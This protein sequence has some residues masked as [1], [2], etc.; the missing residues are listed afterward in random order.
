M[1]SSPNPGPEV[2]RGLVACSKHAADRYIERIEDVSVDVARSRIRR[3]F[4]STRVTK[5]AEFAGTSPYRLTSGNVTY[6]VWGG[7]VATVYPRRRAAQSA[8][9]RRGRTPLHGRHRRERDRAPH[10][11]RHIRP[12]RRRR[13][14]PD[15]R[16][17]VR[18]VNHSAGRVDA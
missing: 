9:G 17:R 14:G 15:R 11:R 18:D 6:C 7:V 5:L 1:Q 10:R 2:S 13:G 8:T 3:C 16:S 12:W 4:E